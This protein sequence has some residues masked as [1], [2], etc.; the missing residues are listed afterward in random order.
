MVKN[1]TLEGLILIP[2]LTNLLLRSRTEKE[3]KILLKSYITLQ[4]KQKEIIIITVQ[5]VEM[6]YRQ[7]KLPR[8][9]Q[10]KNRLIQC[11]NAKS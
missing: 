5:L 3:E 10:D 7:L 1:H 2:Y 11:K 6:Q 9:N 8:Q 4:I